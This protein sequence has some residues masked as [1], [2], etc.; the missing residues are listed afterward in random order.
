MGSVTKVL[1]FDVDTPFGTSPGGQS[2]F[3]RDFVLPLSPAI[4]TTL[5]TIGP[6]DQARNDGPKYQSLVASG[7]MSRRNL[8]L[9]AWKGRHFAHSHDDF[10]L[11]VEQFTSPIGP[12]GLPKVTETPVIGIACYSFWDEMSEKYHIPFNV[13][14]RERLGHYRWLVANHHS[15]ADKLR[16]LSPQAEVIVI[17]QLLDEQTREISDHPGNTALYLGRPDVHQKGLDLLVKALETVAIPGLVVEI[18]GFD[19]NNPRWRRLVRSRRFRCEVRLLGYVKGTAKALAMERAKVLL[20]PSRYEG[21]NLVVLEA[22]SFG[23]PTVAF[24]LACFSDRRD[25]MILS[26]EVSAKGFASALERAWFDTALYERARA[27][28]VE[29]SRAKR[30]SAQV[31]AFREFVEHVVASESSSRGPR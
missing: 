16:R 12:M 10:D 27:R 22:A 14:T 5:A 8:A 25:A 1:C 24:D 18:A 21:P 19:E 11:I 6:V 31:S 13:I 20:V 15:V 26:P 30:G 28:C 2:V 4:D 9:F 17:E 23:V 29:F 7:A 3:T